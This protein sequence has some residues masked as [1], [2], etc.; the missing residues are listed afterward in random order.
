MFENISSGIA[1]VGLS[2]FFIFLDLASIIII[3]RR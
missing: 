2:I 3:I 1:L